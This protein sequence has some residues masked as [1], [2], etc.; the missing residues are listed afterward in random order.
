MFSVVL[1][2]F[3]LESG[4]DNKSNTR[5]H[6][7]PTSRINVRSLTLS[8]CGYPNIPCYFIRFF[9]EKHFFFFCFLFIVGNRNSPKKRTVPTVDVLFYVFYSYFSLF[10]KWL[11]EHSG[12]N[13][14]L[15]LFFLPFSIF[16]FLIEKS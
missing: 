11:Q 8:L 6:I 2:L 12:S 13:K 15:L 5:L 16:C 9:P 7:Y 4:E 14:N 3:Q 1:R 10:K